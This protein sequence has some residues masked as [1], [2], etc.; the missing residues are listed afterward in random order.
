VFW[1]NGEEKKLYKTL[2]PGE[3]YDQQTYVG[4]KWH[5]QT[6]I[7]GDLLLDEVGQEQHINVDIHD[8]KGPPPQMVA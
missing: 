1:I 3:G 6:E 4:H 7:T 5:C 2:T 8:Q